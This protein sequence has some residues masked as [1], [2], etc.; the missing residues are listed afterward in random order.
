MKTNFSRSYVM[1]ITIVAFQLV[2]TS[3]NKDDGL[4]EERENYRISKAKHKNIRI[5]NVT[6]SDMIIDNDS[7]IFKFT[8]RG[9]QKLPFTN[10]P[11]STC[12]SVQR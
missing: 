3:C 5:I 12:A 10:L 4:T 1:L 2:Y 9:F 8:N 6:I 7:G 11:P